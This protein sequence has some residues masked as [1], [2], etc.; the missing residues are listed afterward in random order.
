MKATRSRAWRVGGVV[1]E[2]SF[3]EWV[4]NSGWVGGWECELTE[5]TRRKAAEGRRSPRRFARLGA[6]GGV[7][8]SLSAL[9]FWRSDRGGGLT[10]AC[11]SS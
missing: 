11:E 1:G 6:G 2:S 5:R 7:P 9:V 10:L 3:K 8:A 4:L